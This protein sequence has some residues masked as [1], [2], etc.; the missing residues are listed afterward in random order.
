LKIVEFK[1]YYSLLRLDGSKSFN[2]D[3]PGWAFEKMVLHLNF[4]KDSFLIIFTDIW[5]AQ[6]VSFIFFQL[7]FISSYLKIFI[8]NTQVIGF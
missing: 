8:I 3:L 2:P 4:I 7:Y 5:K 1:V 6:L